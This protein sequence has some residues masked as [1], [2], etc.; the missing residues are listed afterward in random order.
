MA[1]SSSYPALLSFN[2]LIVGARA[3][4][5]CEPNLFADDTFN[6]RNTNESIGTPDSR[7]VIRSVHR[8]CLKPFTCV[9]AQSNTSQL[10]YVVLLYLLSR[11]IRHC[12]YL[13][14]LIHDY[15]WHNWNLSP[16]TTG[17]PRCRQTRA[18]HTLV[19]LAKFRYLNEKSRQK[20]TNVVEE[21]ISAYASRSSAHAEKTYSNKT[22]RFH[23]ST[24]KLVI[25]R[26]IIALIILISSALGMFL[27]R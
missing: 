9:S 5:R 16:K 25:L 1:S 23:F 3:G 11:L 20:A 12:I 27:S 13:L 26:F 10:Q 7:S 24:W 2:H 14:L 8:G 4:H 6:V 21:E 18:A 22:N 15:Y 19:G 17:R